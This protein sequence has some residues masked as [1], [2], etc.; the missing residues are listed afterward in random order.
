RGSIDREPLH[1]AKRL[2]R[3]A[4]SPSVGRRRSERPPRRPDGVAFP[5][6]VSQRTE[7]TRIVARAPRREA[8]LRKQERSDARSRSGLET[9]E[10][11]RADLGG[12]P[13]DFARFRNR[14]PLRARAPR[15]SSFGESP[16]V[17]TSRPCPPK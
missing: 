1:A 14:F 12:R 17:S 4:A 9:M 7:E 15:L 10:P 11:R 8:A 16:C 2:R 5:P 3:G 6:Y 13:A